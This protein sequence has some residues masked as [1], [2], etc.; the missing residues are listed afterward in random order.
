MPSSNCACSTSARCAALMKS[1]CF[2]ALP[3]LTLVKPTLAY[4]RRPQDL[5]L[6]H[7]SEVGSAIPR[8]GCVVGSIRTTGTSVVPSAIKAFS[9]HLTSGLP[10]DR[11]REEEGDRRLP[12]SCW[13]LQ[14]TE[15]FSVSTHH[16]TLRLYPLGH[17]STTARLMYSSLAVRWRLPPL[18]MSSPRVSPP[19]LSPFPPPLPLPRS[20]RP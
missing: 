2:L 20:S 9:C 14:P 6:H 15:R 1:Q 8:H 17:T 7:S 19:N 10:L 3:I 4:I 5:V 12:R 16:C 11:E 18:L 13:C